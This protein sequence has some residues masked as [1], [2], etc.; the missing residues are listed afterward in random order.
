MI[1]GPP[2]VLGGSVI[3]VVWLVVVAAPG[4]FSWASMAVCS[5]ILR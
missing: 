4:H 2:E 5:E 1:A 3:V